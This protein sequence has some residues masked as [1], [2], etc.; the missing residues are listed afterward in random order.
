MLDPSTPLFAYGA[1]PG[2]EFFPY[3]LALLSWVLLAVIGVFLTP[4]MKLIRQL[5]GRDAASPAGSKSEQKGPAP[6]C[7]GQLPPA[8]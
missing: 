4:I 5:R 8:E 7:D 6:P 2:V 1:L 3:F